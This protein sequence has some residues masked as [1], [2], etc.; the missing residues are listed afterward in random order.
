MSSAFVCCKIPRPA[1]PFFTSLLIHSLYVVFFLVFFIYKFLDIFEFHL[2]CRICSSCSFFPS[3]YKFEF[4]FSFLCCFFLSF[5][6]YQS[7]C[8]FFSFALPS[9]LTPTLL[10]AC[11]VR[12]C[13]VEKYT[14][15]SQDAEKTP[16][17]KKK[18]KKMKRK[19]IRKISVLAPHPRARRCRPF[20]HA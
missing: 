6:S 4:P 12:L 16:K 2:L 3:L 15:M 5:S 10:L 9:S 19:N 17:Q 7:N 20:M 13:V 18:S 14:G 8:K 1:L 11:H